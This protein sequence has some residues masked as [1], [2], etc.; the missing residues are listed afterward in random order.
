MRVNVVADDDWCNRKLRDF[1]A[2]A[3]VRLKIES[4]NATALARSHQ[5]GHNRLTSHLINGDET[6][7]VFKIWQSSRYVEPETNCN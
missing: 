4:L 2:A 1:T 6:E 7:N 3:A 5:P